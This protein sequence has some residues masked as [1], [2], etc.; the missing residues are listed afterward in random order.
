VGDRA[1]PRSGRGEPLAAGRASGGSQPIARLLLLAIAVGLLTAPLS[2]CGS[3][4]KPDDRE[5]FLLYKRSGG[6]AGVEFE[7]TCHRDGQCKYREATKPS[8]T[9][10]FISSD[11]IDRVRGAFDAAHFDQ[12]ESTGSPPPA[13]AIRYSILYEGHLVSMTDADPIP[14]LQPVLDAL[15]T[16]IAQVGDIRSGG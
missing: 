5:V 7:L 4:A 1:G 12:L 3:D 9:E 8:A 2:G 13:D 14:E 6:V 11:D 16:L 15:D 10:A